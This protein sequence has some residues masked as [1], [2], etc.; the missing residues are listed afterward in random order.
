MNTG[1]LWDERFAWPDDPEDQRI[2]DRWH[3]SLGGQALKR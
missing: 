3:A 2:I 1:L